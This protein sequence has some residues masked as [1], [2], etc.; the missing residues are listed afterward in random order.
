MYARE[1]LQNDKITY[2]HETTYE[3]ICVVIGMMYARGLLAQAMHYVDRLFQEGFG[4]PIFGATM[5]RDRF[6]FLLRKLSFDDDTKTLEGPQASSGCSMEAF[7]S[8]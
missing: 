2:L 1:I 4:H 5:A 6:K 3:E 7:D 8:R